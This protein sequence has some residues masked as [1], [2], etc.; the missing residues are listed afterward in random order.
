MNLINNSRRFSVAQIM[1]CPALRSLRAAFPAWR[2]LA[3]RL[4]CAIG[5]RTMSSID[6]INRRFSVAPMMDSAD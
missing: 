2:R 4:H 5:L 1:E 3:W 6:I